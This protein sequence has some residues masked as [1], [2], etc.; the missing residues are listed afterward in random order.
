MLV[1]IL[2]LFLGWS[3]WPLRIA[4]IGVIL[5]NLEAIAITFLA[6]EPLSDI[7]HVGQVRR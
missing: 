6:S 5:T 2:S 3:I 7:E 1:G 4:L